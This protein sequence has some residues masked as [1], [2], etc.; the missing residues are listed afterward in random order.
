VQEIHF[1]GTDILQHPDQQNPFRFLAGGYGAGQIPCNLRTGSIPGL[2]GSYSSDIDPEF[3]YLYFCGIFPLLHIAN[4]G[5]FS[6]RSGT[7]FKRTGPF[8]FAKRGYPDFPGF[9]VVFIL[10]K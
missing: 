3:D 4:E 7:G 6:T 9:I 5:L 8:R 2:P 1:F 10:Y